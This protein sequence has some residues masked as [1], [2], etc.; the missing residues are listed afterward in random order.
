MTTALPLD[1][2]QAAARQSAPVALIPN[3]D[4]MVVVNG[5]LNLNKNNAYRLGVDQPLNTE[6][7]GVEHEDLLPEFA[8]HWPGAHLAR[9]ASHQVSSIT[10]RSGGQ[11]AFHLSSAALRQYVWTQ[12]SQLY[13][14][15]EAARSHHAQDGWQR[16]RDRCYDQR[17][18]RRAARQLL[19]QWHTGAWLH[20][21]H[22]DQR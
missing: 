11:F 17:H 12:R 20:R 4:P 10:R 9:R 5:N 8:C 18:H 1:E 16:R 2:L 7:N 15:L 21:H 19:N 22:D 3:F 6:L 13:E 14:S